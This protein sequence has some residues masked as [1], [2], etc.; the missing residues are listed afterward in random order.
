LL[1][2]AANPTL[3]ARAELASATARSDSDGVVRLDVELPIYGGASFQVSARTVSGP[4][5]PSPPIT[6]WRRIY[7]QLTTME[8][9]PDGR[10]FDVPAGLMDALRERLAAVF[11]DLQP[12]TRA[13]ATTPYQE[14]VATNA[15]YDAMA[16][17]ALKDDRSPFKL[18]IVAI[19]NSESFRI[20]KVKL[21]ASAQIETKPFVK[22]KYVATMESATFATLE[23]PDNPKPLEDVQVLD[24]FD[25]KAIITA[26]VPHPHP[27]KVL[28]R[29]KYR[30]AEPTPIGRGGPG[31]VLRICVGYMREHYAVHEIL[32]LLCHVMLHEIGHAFG[33]VPKTA[34]WADPDPRDQGYEVIHCR[35][36]EG[37]GSPE[38]VMWFKARR[39]GIGH[40]C[41]SHEPHNCA[42]YLRSLDLSKMEWI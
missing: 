25:G 15:E 18:H 37:D 32:P 40:Y 30:S 28:I 35:H 23:E 1:P 42:H 36:I 24:Q 11:I 17:A 31:G 3:D 6:V 38:C 14:N 13:N 22:S 2:D 10:R 21:Y 7:Y 8:P 16:S 5:V 4:L 39:G 19:D 29:L 34:S 9:A 33:L 27:W 41:T 12:G 20:M 26:R